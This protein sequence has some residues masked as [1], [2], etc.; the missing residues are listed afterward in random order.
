MG[1]GCGEADEVDRYKG[2]RYTYEPIIYL[3]TGH[4]K[5]RERKN[6]VQ[7]LGFGVRV[8]Q[9]ADGADMIPKRTWTA[10]PNNNESEQ[11]TSVARSPFILLFPPPDLWAFGM[12]ICICAG[13]CT[14]LY[15]LGACPAPRLAPCTLRL[16]SFECPQLTRTA[17]GGNSGQEGKWKCRWK[18]TSCPAGAGRALRNISAA[19]SR[20]RPLGSDA[21]R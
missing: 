14:G 5:A 11:P 18:R 4:R 6:K 10:G 17:R 9:P 16:A 19:T 20:G 8:N 2:S 13:Y 15:F 7:P 21:G 12:G 3:V 1:V